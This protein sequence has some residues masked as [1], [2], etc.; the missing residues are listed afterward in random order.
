MSKPMAVVF[1]TLLHDLDE[2]WPGRNQLVLSMRHER[3]VVMLGAAPGG[4]RALLRPLPHVHSYQNGILRV[5]GAFALSGRPKLARIARPLALLE[6][7]LLRRLLAKHG[8]PRYLVWLT[9][10]GRHLAE[11]R[12]ANGVL[13]DCADPS[14]RS[15]QDPEYDR[16]EERDVRGADLVLATAHTLLA[17]VSRWNPRAFL[18]PNATSRYEAGVDWAPDDGPRTVGYVGTVDRRFD[19]AAV[20]AAA[21]ALPDWTFVIIGRVNNPAD[22]DVARLVALSNV[23]ITGQLPEAEARRRLAQ[24]N[25]GLIP[26]TP[27]PMNDAINSVKMFDFFAYGMPVAALD[28]VEN[29]ANEFVDVAEHPGALAETIVRA[30]TSDTPELRARRRRWAAHNTWSVRAAEATALL[31]R[32]GLFP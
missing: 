20:A 8:I 13:Y 19:S 17:R 4:R 12:G 24:F 30:W 22:P 14:F 7:R 9:M 29:R 11:G 27:R 18:V 5:G 2:D 25:V 23:E 6:G 32:E 26:F 15:D 1:G 21:A 3:T 16:A 28:T 10:P 31:T